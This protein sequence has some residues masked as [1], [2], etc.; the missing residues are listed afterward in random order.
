MPCTFGQGNDSLVQVHVRDL[1]PGQGKSNILRQQFSN[2]SGNVVNSDGNN[3]FQNIYMEPGSG[4]DTS[5]AAVSVVSLGTITSAAD[6]WEGVTLNLD[7]AATSRYTFDIGMG[8]HAILRDILTSN[9]S[10]NVLNVNV[11]KDENA[12]PP[13]MVTAPV[14]RTVNYSTEPTS[15]TICTF[16]N[17][18]A[19]RSVGTMKY[20]LDC[21]TAPT[22]AG[23]GTGH[24]AVS[25]GTNW[26]CQ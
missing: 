3:T 7:L 16:A 25:N 6:V 13:F 21:T 2:V 18:G 8:A 4:A 23:S 14:N 9:M 1:T 12:T 10:P 24:M 15:I 22:C 5:T 19:V 26:T 11:V 17:L 20:C